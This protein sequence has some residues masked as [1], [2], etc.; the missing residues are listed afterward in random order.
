MPRLAAALA[1]LA[2]ALAPAASLAAEGDAD[3]AAKKRQR[4]AKQLR[5]KAFGSC[6]GLV[7][8]GRRHA[9]QGPGA[10][11]PPSADLPAPLI[12]APPPTPAPGVPEPLPVTAV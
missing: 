11:E 12:G 3:A 1:L 9:R 10:L 5:L 8:Y 6:N 7:R 2:L 4:L